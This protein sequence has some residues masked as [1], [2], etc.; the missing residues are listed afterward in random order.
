MGADQHITDPDDRADLAARAYELLH[1]YGSLSKVR[2]HLAAALP[3]PTI[4]P[5]AHELRC[6][7]TACRGRAG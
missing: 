5:T 7:E 6:G 2:E 4:H 3:V 1:Q